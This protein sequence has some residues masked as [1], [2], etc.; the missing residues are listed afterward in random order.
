MLFRKLRD[1]ALELHDGEIYAGFD[2]LFDLDAA[3]R[4]RR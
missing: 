1:S 4:L 3:I 2:D